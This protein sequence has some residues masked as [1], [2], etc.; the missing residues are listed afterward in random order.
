MPADKSKKQMLAHEEI[1]GLDIGPRLTRP[2]VE[3]LAGPGADKGFT[4]TGIRE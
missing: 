1:K 4:G 3:Q 2:D